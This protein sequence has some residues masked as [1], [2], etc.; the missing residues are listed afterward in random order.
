MFRRKVRTFLTI[1][2]ITIGIFALTVMGALAIKLNK[3][4]SE[5]KKFVTSQI[6]VLPKGQSDPS[7]GTAFLTTQ[8]LDQ[9]RKI[10]GVAEVR[11][12]VAL[13][14]EDSQALSF[15]PSE[16][17][18]GIS[19]EGDLSHAFR[20]LT[21]KEG[22][23]LRPGDTD[24]VVIGANAAV[25]KG[26]KLN[27]R[28]TLRGATFTVVGI[29]D[30]TE[31]QVD[32]YVFMPIAQAQQLLVNSNQFLKSLQTQSSE[33]SRLTESTLASLPAAQ[34]ASLEQAS[35]FKADQVVTTAS[36]YWDPGVDTEALSKTIQRDVTG[37][38][39]YSPQDFAKV[40]DQA[41]V[42]LNL[43]VLGSAAIA[44]LVGS[45]SVINTMI[46]AISERTREI[47]VKRA[48][49]A[50]TR[51]ILF[52]YLTE[53]GMIGFFG[54]LLGLGFGSLVASLVNN[55]TAHTGTQLFG[56][57]PGLAIGVVGFAVVLGI[58][59]GIYPA[60]HAARINPVKALR[61]E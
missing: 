39:V 54:G 30:K 22:R 9:I 31:G 13:P 50:K 35:A 12:E 1:F 33:A 38:T 48:I 7:A 61:S 34:R 23:L 3:S 5:S 8:T 51:N 32:T 2:G 6:T 60:V 43:I 10:K 57:T 21:A 16:T 19:L 27:Q 55:A 59:A 20:G 18:D 24:Q 44:L 47:G 56:V 15:D 46:M 29:L 58:V 14:A 49:G 42:T 36:V 28:I 11:P 25:D 40:I 26:W 45:L 17:I 52:E 53:A 37:L 4:I 41:T